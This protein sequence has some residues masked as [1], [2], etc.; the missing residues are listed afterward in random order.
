MSCDCPYAADG[1][2]CKHEAALLYALAEEDSG[3]D[4]KDDLEDD[5]EH[6]SKG[7]KHAK[8]PFIERLEAERE[9]LWSL[10]R[11][12]TEDEL[13][14]LLYD[15]ASHDESLRNR[16]VATYRESIDEKYLLQMKKMISGICCNHSDCSGYDEN[17]G[18][19]IG[20]CWSIEE[21]EE[22]CRSKS[23][24]TN[25]IPVEQARQFLQ[26]MRKQ[27]FKMRKKR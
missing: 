5:P 20:S 12:M 16:I 25:L 26:H 24:S 13:R 19:H 11:N 1:S 15:L 2:H 23:C 9:E 22:L 18:E 8:P 10:I 17:T 21:A 7:R 4:E 14:K 3:S 6:T 27:R